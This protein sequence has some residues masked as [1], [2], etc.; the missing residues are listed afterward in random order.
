MLYLIAIFNGFFAKAYKAQDHI[1]D[2][3]NTQLNGPN[4]WGLIQDV[5]PYFYMENVPSTMQKISHHD[6]LHSPESAGVYM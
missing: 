1:K 4:E 5:N 2:P 6:S 3:G